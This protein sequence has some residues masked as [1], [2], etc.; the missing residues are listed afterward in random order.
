MDHIIPTSVDV[1]KP[2][3]SNNPDSY[4]I[5]LLLSKLKKIFKVFEHLK[6]F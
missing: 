6:G 2:A 5:G 4:K 3:D 1:L